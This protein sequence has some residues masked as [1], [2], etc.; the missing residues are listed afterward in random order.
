[1]PL[2]IASYCLKK[3]KSEGLTTILNPAPYFDIDNTNFKLVDYLTPNEHE[4]S[5]LTKLKFRI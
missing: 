1:M 3:A 4:A 5:S 2:E